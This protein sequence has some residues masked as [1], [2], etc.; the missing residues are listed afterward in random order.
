MQVGLQALL[1]LFAEGL[2]TALLLDSGD[3][4][5]HCIPVYEGHM[6]TNESKR[7]NLAGRHVTENLTKLLFQR[8]YAFNS[9]ADFELVRE[10][11]EKY[12]YVSAD[13]AVDNKLDRETTCLEKEFVLPDKSKIKIGKERFY[14]SEILFNPCLLGME[15]A[16]CSDMLFNSINECAIDLR[17]SLYGAILISGGTT[18]MPGFPTRLYNDI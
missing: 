1:P 10:I 4:V 14:A 12:C 9:T 11:K 3:G 17:R 7:L 16:G 8:G 6:L 5:T 15:A 2:M 13:L 18:M